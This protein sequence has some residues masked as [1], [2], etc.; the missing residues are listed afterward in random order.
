[1]NFLSRTIDERFLAHRR[2]STSIAGIICAVLAICLFEWRYFVDHH[3]N[4]DLLAIGLTFVV[5]K[6]A[7]MVFYYLTD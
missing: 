7:L 5:V 4:W 3:W 2:Q 6:L 1:M